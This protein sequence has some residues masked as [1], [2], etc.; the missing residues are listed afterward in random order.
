[1]HA[2]LIFGISFIKPLFLDPKNNYCLDYDLCLATGLI[3]CTV[4][5]LQTNLDLSCEQWSK[6]YNPA[7]CPLSGNSFGVLWLVGVDVRS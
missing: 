2:P 6:R 4:S 1:M 7:A 3:S 5:D